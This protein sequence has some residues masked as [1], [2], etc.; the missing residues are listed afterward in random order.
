MGPAS[1]HASMHL[2][3]GVAVGA[4]A[5][6]SGG[7]QQVS[8]ALCCCHH[9]PSFPIRDCLLRAV[10]QPLVDASRFCSVCWPQGMKSY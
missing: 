1:N 2:G 6:L 4:A 5:G 9:M 3:L 8:M 7:M 10:T